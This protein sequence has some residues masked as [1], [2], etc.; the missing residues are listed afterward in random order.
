M[1]KRADKVEAD[2]GD[3]AKVYYHE[4]LGITAA[5]LIDFPSGPLGE[6]AA[7]TGFQSVIP[8]AHSFEH[9]LKPCGAGRRQN[10]G[11]LISHARHELS[12]WPRLMKFHSERSKSFLIPLHYTWNVR[13]ERKRFV[14]QFLAISVVD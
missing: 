5:C 11:R 6:L 10:G 7:L 13:V 3:H 14:G 8:I 12:R 1:G 9:G 4:N 2:F